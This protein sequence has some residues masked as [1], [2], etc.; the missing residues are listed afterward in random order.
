MELRQ[1]LFLFP[2]LPAFFKSSCLYLEPN[3]Q[4]PV[5]AYSPDISHLGKNLLSHVPLEYDA[6]ILKLP[7]KFFQY[8]LAKLFLYSFGLPLELF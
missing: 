7:N 8:V 3:C 6:P 5:Q 4:T 2:K 1:R